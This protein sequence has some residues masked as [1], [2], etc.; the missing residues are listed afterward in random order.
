MG[1]MGQTG[2]R[3]LMK[4][5]ISV[6]HGSFMQKI[7]PSL[8]HLSQSTIDLALLRDQASNV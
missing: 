5:S 4:F 2:T 6:P 7:C 3:F 8:S 1:Q